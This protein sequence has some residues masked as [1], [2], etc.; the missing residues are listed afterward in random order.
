MGLRVHKPSFVNAAGDLSRAGVV[1]KAVFARRVVRA[2]TSGAAHI[3]PAGIS[4]TSWFAAAPGDAMQHRGR[5]RLWKRCGP[6]PG[7]VTLRAPGDV[8][9]VMLGR[10][11][12]SGR[13][14]SWRDA[15]FHPRAAL[16]SPGSA[17]PFPGRCR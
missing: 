10:A 5:R 14:P 4:A 12:P 13:R 8:P 6:S 9:G 7:A 11:L 16:A 1:L 2:L 15:R 17:V 3:W